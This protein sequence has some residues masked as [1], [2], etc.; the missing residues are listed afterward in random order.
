MTLV[1]DLRAPERPIDAL[2]AELRGHRCD[3]TPSPDGTTWTS[4]CPNHPP[5]VA[6]TITI[7]TGPAGA[8]TSMECSAGCQRPEKSDPIDADPGR[9][10]GHP[11]DATPGASQEASA[12]VEFAL[13]GITHAEAVA[14]EVAPTSEVVR[15]LIEAATVG[16]IAGLPET[17]KSFLAVEIG[18]KVASGRGKVLGRFPIVKSGPVGYIWQDDSEANELR[19][20]QAYA[21]RHGHNGDLPIR[22]YLN[23][24]LRLPEHIAE[25]RRIVERDLLVLLVLDSLYNIASGDLKDEAIGGLYE[26]LKREVCNPTGVAILI[27]DHAPWP[28][29]GNKGQRRSYG[30]VFKRAAIRWAIHLERIGDTVFAEANGNNITGF[31]RAAAIWH[32]DELELRLVETSITEQD[33]GARLADFLERNPG[34][35][36]SFIERGVQGKGK[37]IR[38]LLESDDRFEPV[39][40]ALFGKPSNARCWARAEDASN[41]IRNSITNL[42]PER[43]DVGTT[44]PERP[45]RTNLVPDPSLRSRGDEVED[46]LDNVVLDRDDGAP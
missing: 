17:H 36:T 11:D 26:L 22:W 45:P 41:L 28:T 32:P 35:T 31:K 2:L 39:P 34:A 13:R 1:N 43:D 7:K 15:D 20:L 30:T 33:L 25:L 44:L 18:C 5:G 9:E 23:E 29:E 27:V 42:V 46:D 21:H 38:D 12:R 8:I 24:G 3:P 40:P 6:A 16:E 10:E 4:R 19:R 14:R 37:Q